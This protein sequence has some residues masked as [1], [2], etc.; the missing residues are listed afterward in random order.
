MKITIVGA[1]Y[2]GL[3]TGACF[4]DAGHTVRCLDINQLKVDNLKKGI[5]RIYEKRLQNLIQSNYAEKRLFF[6][7]SYE[8]ALISS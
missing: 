4:A 5:L 8:Q 6:T 1:G 3:V 2:V 7:T